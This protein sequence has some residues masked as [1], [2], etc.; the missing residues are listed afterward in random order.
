VPDRSLW[1]QVQTCAKEALE[2]EQRAAKLEAALQHEIG[3]QRAAA[4]SLEAAARAAA[5]RCKKLL[6]DT[7]PGADMQSQAQ[8]QARPAA[9]AQPASTPGQTARC[10]GGAERALTAGQP[11]PSSAHMPLVPGAA[12]LCGKSSG[13]AAVASQHVAATCT[14]AGKSKAA[15]AAAEAQATGEPTALATARNVYN[16]PVSPMHGALID[17][18]CTLDDVAAQLGPTDTVC[19]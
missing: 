1:L 10:S 11:N 5:R 3:R 8:P 9:V 2:R 13:R 19:A 14:P 12:A 6:Y 15:D 17:A 18:Q 4:E 7:Q 16:T